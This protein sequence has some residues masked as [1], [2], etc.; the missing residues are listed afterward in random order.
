MCEILL[1]VV[2]KVNLDNIYL[3]AM[4]TKFGDVI[5]VMENGGSWGS[6]DKTNP[7]WKIISIPDMPVSE[8]LIYME[9]DNSDIVVVPRKR[10]KG[11]SI[12]KIPPPVLN[13]LQAP[14]SGDGIDYTLTRASVLNY[15]NVKTAIVDPAAL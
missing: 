2:D 9:G 12:D 7:D 11:M 15:I 1:R 5:A 14:R 10:N 13:A 3:D 6:E 4:C 8:A